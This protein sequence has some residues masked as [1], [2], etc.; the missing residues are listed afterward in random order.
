M[1][2]EGEVVVFQVVAIHAGKHVTIENQRQ[3]AHFH[4]RTTAADGGNVI[5]ARLV[6][7][8]VDRRS[9]EQAVDLTL[10]EARLHLGNGIGIEQI[11]LVD[12]HLVDQAAAGKTGGQQGGDEE[13]V[14]RGFHGIRK[15]RR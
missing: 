1:A 7:S 5:P 11:A 3:V 6:E 15:T 8:I 9:A 13:L 4:R 10:G 2:V 12:I 14:H